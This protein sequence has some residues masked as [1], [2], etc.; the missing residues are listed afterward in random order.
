MA[1]NARFHN[2]WHRKD[3]HS[4]PTPG[5]PSSAT[6]PIASQEEPFVGDFVVYNSISA[7][8]DLKIDGSATIVG[9]LSVLGDFTYLDTIV[10]VTSA[11]SVVNTG[12]GPALTVVQLGMQPIARFIDGDAPAGQAYAFF[13]ENNGQAVFSG[14]VPS[15]DRRVSIYGTLS[16]SGN[17]E[18]QAGSASG[19]RN[20]A[21]NT[22]R[23]FGTDSAAFGTGL[24]TGVHAFAEG[25]STYAAG[26]ASHAEGF[27]TSALGPNSHA[28]GLSNTASGSASHAEGTG[29]TASGNYAHAEG[30]LNTASGVASHAEGLSNT[31]SGSASHAEGFQSLASGNY[32]HAE[33]LSNTASGSASH[34][35][36]LRSTASGDY[37]FAHGERVL[38]RNQ[39]SFAMGFSAKSVHDNSF[40]FSS[41][42]TNVYNSSSFGHDT[43]NVFATGGIDLFDP[44]TVGDPLFPV[45]F[46]VTASS[47]VGVNIYN[48]AEALS[49]VGNISAT[50]GLSAFNGY[51]RS[52]A[53]TDDTPV[54]RVLGSSTKSVFGQF[55]NFTAGASASTDISVYNN[56][57]NYLNMG[58]ASS[59]YNGNLY[60]PV[61]NVVGAGD[62][63]LYTTTNDL[64]IGTSSAGTN[65]DII[66]FTGGTLSG[67]AGNE[68]MRITNA[69]NVGIGTA[70]PAEKLTVSGNISAYGTLSAA[71]AGGN[72]F[73][74]NV[75]I[76][77]NESTFDLYVKRSSVGTV[78]PESNS[79]AVFEGGGGANAYV[80]II[81]QDA[82]ASGV[83]FGSPS[84]ALG[85]YLNWNYNNNALKLATASNNGLIQLLTNNEAEAVRITSSGNVGIGTTAPAEKLTVAGGISGNNGLSALNIYCLAQTNSTAVSAVTLTAANIYGS[86]TNSTV[87]SAVTLTAQDVSI[88]GT[89]SSGAGILANSL[90]SRF[91]S[92]VH[93]PANDGNNARLDIGETDVNPSLGLVGFSGFNVTYN[94]TNNKLVITSTFGGVTLTAA[95]IDRFGNTGGPVFPSTQTLGVAITS[96]IGAAFQNVYVWP[97]ALSGVFTPDEVTNRL[98]NTKGRLY[99]KVFVGTTNNVNNKT[100]ALQIANNST[101]T[102]PGSVI[103][104]TFNSFSQ[105]TRPFECVPNGSTLVFGDSASNVP[106]GSSNQGFGSYAITPGDPIFYRFGYRLATITDTFAFSGGYITVSPY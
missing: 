97:P 100:L 56:T 34:A 16:A 67:S 68:R 87:I 81:S 98:N 30:V 5:Y 38:A 40:V 105:L 96:V 95:T 19:S 54:L 36:G 62:S 78:T 12:T 9:N 33:G 46:I 88:Y 73:A 50:G 64:I 20:L 84:D 101:F 22:G 74:G 49:V 25:R 48:P 42:S 71:G 11:L 65:N 6:D 90:S 39:E 51:F 77:T 102:N 41:K 63:Y 58:I 59:T 80:S 2:K 104:N 55:Q 85:A 83:V 70:V 28:E 52:S 94:E 29:T 3:H 26:S 86:V 93:S 44:V 91:I 103:V 69:G 106:D 18:F 89:L 27:G 53:T 35:G 76:G 61:F 21:A 14:G 8:Q 45:T 66:L 79:V 4:R 43:F 47:T 13:L 7:H 82:Q 92:L 31:A 60:A 57:N 23:A 72:Y 37:S 24:A 75:G 32:S 1:G 15:L 10:S 17:T 99:G